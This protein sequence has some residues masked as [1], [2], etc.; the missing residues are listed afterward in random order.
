M[1]VPPVRLRDASCCR[2]AVQHEDLSEMRNHNDQKVIEK[3]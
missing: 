2:A 3:P 1:R